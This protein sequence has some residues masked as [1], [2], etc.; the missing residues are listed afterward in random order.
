[1]LLGKIE[2]LK[3]TPILAGQIGIC[4]YE[5][6]I[7]NWLPKCILNYKDTKLAVSKW[8]SPKRTRSYPYA[9]VYDTFKF[10]PQRKVTIIPIVKDEGFDGD[11]DYLQW[12]TVSL[13]SLLNVYI[14][15]GNYNDAELNYRNPK[16]KDK[17]TNQKFDSDFIKKRFEQLENYHADAL[18]WNLS[19]L[20]PDELEFLMDKVIR[21]YDSISEKLKVKMH[22]NVGLEK[23]KE[24]IKLHSDS[25][26]ES[27]RKKALEAQNRESLTTQ[28]KEAIEE[29]KKA[30]I[31]I[32][33]YIG[34]YYYFTVD[35]LLENH[36]VLELVESKHSGGSLLPAI[37]DIKDGL[38][39][40]I[41]FSNISQLK[42]DSEEKQFRAVLRLTSTKLQ[43][44]CNSDNSEAEVE[45]FIALNKLE[46]YRDIIE[47]IFKE[48]KLNDF[49]IR[50]E[51]SQ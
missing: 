51:R 20:K 42:I 33:N 15:L 8:V 43:V 14:V 32:K 9:R 35:N 3:Y 19:Q 29:G 41:I 10:S 26:K 23:F 34:G 49:V 17:I 1:M 13:M 5:D 12:D 27:S 25:F 22:S 47:N 44:G 24:Q 6:D 2:N 46:K 38:L 39:K 45:S 11:R 28:P 18:H 4:E 21:D 16:K 48:A 50:I 30:K 7:N 40:M 36:G 37:D 31:L